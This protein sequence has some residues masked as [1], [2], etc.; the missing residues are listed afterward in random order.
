MSRF[1]IISL[2]PAQ[3]YDFSALAVMECIPEKEGNVYRLVSVKRKQKLPYPEIV[4]WAEHVFRNP[5]FQRSEGVASPQLVIDVGGVGRALYDM[6]GAD[7]VKCIAIQY[8]GGGDIMSF[9]NGA[10]CIGKSALVGKFLAAWDDGRVRVPANSSFR[11]TLVD[12][13]KAFRGHMSSQGRARFEAEQG[14]HDDQ[15]MAIAQ[16]VWWAETRPK[17]HPPLIFGGAIKPAAIPGGAATVRRQ[18]DYQHTWF[19]EAAKHH[20]GGF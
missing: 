2:D 15:I 19:A 8:T 20:N 13:L 5:Q 4:Q 7:G 1:W 18:T 10:Y 6:I 14:E 9:N 16:A 3:L 12:E 11:D 17:P